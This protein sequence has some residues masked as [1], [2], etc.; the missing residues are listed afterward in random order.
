MM[1]SESKNTS[2]EPELDPASLDAIRNLMA[3]Q[4]E[5]EVPTAMP[6]RPSAAEKVDTEM[7]QQGSTPLAA[8]A[9]PP[10]KADGLPDLAAAPPEMPRSDPPKPSMGQKLKS[11]FARKPRA[12][13]VKTA[14]V[15]PAQPH[16]AAASAAPAAAPRPKSA[17]G[18]KI[19]ALKAKVL[20]Y[21]PTRKHIFWGAF[22]L[23]V[24]M[25]PW[26]V[27]GLFFLSL[28]VLVGVFLILGY[29]GFW[30]R[31]MAIGRWYARRNPERSVELHRKLDRF[32]MRWDMILDRFPEGS[33]DGLYMPDFGDLAEADARHEE[34][35]ERRLSSLQ[36]TEA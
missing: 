1:Q 25:R 6:T 16:V 4:Q 11:K 13:K 34:A 24:L 19:D 20:G 2:D 29:D 35:M 23:L 30:R 5:P 21:R 15:A 28:F 27:V 17:L 3:G 22:A 18:L 8:P 14:P 12:K 36:Q 7:G 10:R 9:M 31:A 26:L 33:V 32:A